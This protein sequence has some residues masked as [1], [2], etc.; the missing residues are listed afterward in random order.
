MK[1]ITFKVHVADVNSAE[2]QLEIEVTKDYTTEQIEEEV[3]HAS[4]EWAMNFIDFGHWD[5]KEE[6]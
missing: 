4:R 2:E 3:D 5:I 1:K 6:K